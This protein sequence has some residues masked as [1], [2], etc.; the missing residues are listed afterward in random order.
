MDAYGLYNSVVDVYSLYNSVVDDY[1]LYNS[2]VG[3]Y[4]LYN[5]VTI[6]LT[7]PWVHV[8]DYYECI[9]IDKDEESR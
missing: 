8:S 6:H 1:G 2:V 7:C 3:V 4:G 5:S 9:D